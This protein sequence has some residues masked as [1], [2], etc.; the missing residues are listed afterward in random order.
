MIDVADEAVDLNASL[1]LERRN[2]ALEEWESKGITRHEMPAEDRAQWSDA[3][4]D[5]PGSWIK[6]M[7]DKGLPGRDV[8]VNCIEMLEELGHEFPRDWAAD[9]RNP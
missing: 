2:A 7:E 3:L 6:E 5:I 8:M 4:D 9:Y 1:I